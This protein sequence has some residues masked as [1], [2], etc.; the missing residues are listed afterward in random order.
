MATASS[1]GP[2]ILDTYDAIFADLGAAE[3][4]LLRP[5]NRAEA[6]D[7]QVAD[8]LADVDAVFMTG[9]Q[10]GQAVRRHHRHAVRRRGP[11]GL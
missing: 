10:P 5:E 8:Q 3:S 9:R 11:G 2:E 1:L 6:D 7:P 4:V